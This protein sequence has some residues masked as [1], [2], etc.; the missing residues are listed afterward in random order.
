ML[1]PKQVVD[2]WAPEL[3]KKLNRPEETVRAEGLSAYDF[4]SCSSVDLKFSDNSYAHFALAFSIVSKDRNL[5]A[6]FTEHCG[7]MV[8]P[9]VPEMQ[10]IEREENVYIHE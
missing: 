6:V 5:V 2:Q 4:S 3:A 10:V 7:Y 1:T 9:L 8:F